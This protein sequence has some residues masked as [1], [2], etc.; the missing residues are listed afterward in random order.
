MKKCIGQIAVILGVILIFAGLNAALY[1]FLTCRLSNNFSGTDQIKMVDVSRYLPF[2]EG[3]E[4][5]DTDTELHITGDLPVLDGA[6]ALV[7]VY[8]ALI[9][10]LY[11]EGSVT[12]EGGSFSD[13]NYYGENFAADSAMQYKN[14]IRGFKAVTDGDTDVFF[15]AAPSSEQMKYAEEKGVTLKMV[16]VGREGFIFFVHQKNPVED[17]SAEAIRQIYE[18]KIRNWKELG[19]PNRAINP[20]TRLQGSGSQ[21]AMEHFMGERSFGMKSPLVM[22]GASIGYSFRY[23]FSDMVGNREVKMISVNGKSPSPENIRTGDY[24]LAT[25]FYAVYREDNENPNIPVLLDWLSSEEG[26]RF[27]DRT[28]YV[29]MP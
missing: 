5:A 24:P 12:Y 4:L 18:G 15:C 20:V 3:A 14:T 17:L 26:K 1:Q 8:A 13:D 7:P 27:I 19:G 25:E 2:T 10:G 9:N 11:P 6:A 21:T 22:G 29:S 28:G 16:P 23:Y